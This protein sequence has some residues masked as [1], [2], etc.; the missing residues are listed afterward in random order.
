M[1][2]PELGKKIATLRAEQGLT[3]E[4]L[5]DR[6]NISV[7]TIQRIEAGEVT[8]RNYTIRT[9][10]EALGHNLDQLRCGSD[11]PALS[12]KQMNF[13]WIAGIFY[14]L[15]ALPEGLFDY[16]RWDN[17][18]DV[19]YGSSTTVGYILTKLGVV[20]AF[21]FFM[22]GFVRLGEFLSDNLMR[23]SSNILIGLMALLVSLDILSLFISYLFEG[24]YLIPMSISV[25]IVGIIFGI[26][27]IRHQGTLGTVIVIAGVMEIIA[28]SFFLFLLP[29]GLLFLIPAEIFEIISLYRG[30]ELASKGTVSGNQERFATEGLS[31]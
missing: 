6:C 15:L 22:R 18:W 28:G 26:S 21:F 11:M 23:I 8:P 7:R 30:H 14:F 17:D 4:E 13:G 12:L 10:M 2:Q 1:K 27:L 20:I 24:I 5:V 25:G 29:F 16:Y 19:I 3:Q 9:I 31:V